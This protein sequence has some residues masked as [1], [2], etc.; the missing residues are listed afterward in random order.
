MFVCRCNDSLGWHPEIEKFIY[1]IAEDSGI[2]YAQSISVRL[3]TRGRR[4]NSKDDSRKRPYAIRARLLRMLSSGPRLQRVHRSAQ[5]TEGRDLPGHRHDRAMA[6]TCNLRGEALR[7]L[8]MT[9]IG[10]SP[11]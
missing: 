4:F 2:E 3:L 5:P 10:H 1:N 8:K 6:E 7:F 9:L 11:L